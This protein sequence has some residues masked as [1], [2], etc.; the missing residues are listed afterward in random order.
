MVQFDAAPA[1]PAS[2]QWLAALSAGEVAD[3]RRRGYVVDKSDPSE[4]VC[5]PGISNHSEP[6]EDSM[7]DW[8]A[9]MYVIWFCYIFDCFEE[10]SK[11]LYAIEEIILE[12]KAP[13]LIDV[14]GRR[15]GTL[16]A[17]TGGA[18]PVSKLSRTRYIEALA[19]HYAK[20]IAI[21]TTWIS[22]PSW[23]SGRAEDA[24]FA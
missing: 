20:A 11:P 17:G 3:A 21:L 9:R 13:N 16:Y 8:L 14:P 24:D 12:F 22:G 1:V 2:Y 7:Q 15:L 18:E 6:V 10:I 19:P 23:L 5:R 4:P